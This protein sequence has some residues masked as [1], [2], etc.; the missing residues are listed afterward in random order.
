MIDL[1]KKIY[2]ECRSYDIDKLKSIL[3]KVSDDDTVETLI[4][5]LYEIRKV[6]QI[7]PNSIN[8]TV[9]PSDIQSGSSID[10]T[11]S[12]F[13]SYTLNMYPVYGNFRVTDDEENSVAEYITQRD[14][15]SRSLPYALYG[16]LVNRDEDA[17]KVW[18][19][20]DR[21]YA[22]VH[23]ASVEPKPTYARV[24][25]WYCCGIIHL[26]KS[27]SEADA[28]NILSNV[29]RHL[30]DVFSAR[31]VKFGKKITQMEVIQTVMEADPRIRYFDAGK[32]DKK[33]IDWNEKCFNYKYFN[34]ISIMRFY[35]YSVPNSYW[36]SVDTDTTPKFN[37]DEDGIELLSIDSSCIIG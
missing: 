4:K 25:D 34:P 17:S 18:T 6:V 19:F 29:K 12:E 30:A 27:V 33:L 16:L 24:F 1:N 36:D 3:G 35:Q 11:D 9:F 5:K 13:K 31:N 37:Q 23:I 2:N 14:S 22:D 10:F 28:E 21:E 32:G 15:D 8:P 7:D 20:I 26:T